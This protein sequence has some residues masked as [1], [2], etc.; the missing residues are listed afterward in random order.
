MTLDHGYQQFLSLVAKGRNMDMDKVQTVAEGR[1]FHGKEAQQL[2]LVDE[3]GT[4]E[5]AIASAAK[6]A[7]LEEYS[8]SYIEKPRTLRDEMLGIFKGEVTSLLLRHTLSPSLAGQMA[9][10]VAPVR[11]FLLFNDPAGLYAHSLIQGASLLE[12]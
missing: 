12:P 5:D 2:G 7:K 11:E 1:V 8:A 10:L 6:M 9:H 3:I 4:L